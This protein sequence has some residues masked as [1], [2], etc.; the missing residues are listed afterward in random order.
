MKIIE[1][2]A[3]GKKV[4]HPHIKIARSKTKDLMEQLKASIEERSTRRK[5]S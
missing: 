1:A 3:H 4:A 2:K 5:A